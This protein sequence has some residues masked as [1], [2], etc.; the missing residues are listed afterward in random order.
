ML[1]VVSESYNWYA[2]SEVTKHAGHS[3]AQLTGIGWCANE[4]AELVPGWAE[5]PSKAG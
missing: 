5:E 4:E 1:L 3:G 2:Y